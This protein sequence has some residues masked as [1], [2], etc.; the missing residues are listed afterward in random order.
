MTNIY[1]ER[2]FVE[3]EMLYAGSGAFNTTL[4]AA[5]AVDAGSGLVKLPIAADIIDVGSWVYITGTTNYNGTRLVEAISTGFIHVAETYTAETFTT[6]DLVTPTLY[7]QCVFELIGFEMNIGTAPTTSENLTV[8]KDA[9]DG[10]DYDVVYLTQ[11]M[12]GVTDLV[13]VWGKPLRCNA[14]DKIVFAWTN[15]DSRTYG[16]KIIYRRMQ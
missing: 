15:T 2:Y 8:T 11:D 14:D 7:P 5:D 12:S 6:A 16:L 1:N 9:G 4:K 3:D 10:S 13:K